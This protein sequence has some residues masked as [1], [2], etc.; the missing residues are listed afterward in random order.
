MICI[1]HSHKH[2]AVS[3]YKEILILLKVATDGVIG[4][5]SSASFG[6]IPREF[7]VDQILIAPF[8][9]DVDT[10]ISGSITFEEINNTA[11]LQTAATY[12]Q[13]AFPGYDTFFPHL[14]VVITWSDVGYY[15]RQTDKV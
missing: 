13:N 1:L 3:Y 4:F 8:W 10:R 5:G 15:D 9:G 14:L 7:P 12:I 6:N 2:V 11:S